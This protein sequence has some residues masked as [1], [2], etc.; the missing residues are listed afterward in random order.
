MRHVIVSCSILVVGGWAARE[1]EVNGYIGFWKGERFEVYAPTLYDG[2]MAVVA[3][4]QAKHPR[5][6][7]KP[8]DVN[9]ALAEIDGKPYVHIAVN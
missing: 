1:N 3:A 6:K 8:A 9:V 5:A 7:V 2:K 4:A